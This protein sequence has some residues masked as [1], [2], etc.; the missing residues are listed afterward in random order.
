[1]MQA[2]MVADESRKGQ[3]NEHLCGQRRTRMMEDLQD[4]ELQCGGF[5]AS[6]LTCAVSWPVSWREAESGMCCRER[7]AGCYTF[8]LV[9]WR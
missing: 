2:K 9:G 1:M 3:S 8:W 4:E 5:V 6:L 7:R